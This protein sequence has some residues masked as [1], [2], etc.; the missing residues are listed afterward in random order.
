MFQEL[1]RMTTG[2][3]GLVGANES[4]DTLDTSGNV[5]GSDFDDETE[6]SVH[7]PFS[8]LLHDAEKDEGQDPPSSTTGDHHEKPGKRA[9]QGQCHPII[10]SA[11]SHC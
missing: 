1:E 3:D 7:M 9:S 4:M 10:L 11:L 5:T 8:E 2:E 6:E